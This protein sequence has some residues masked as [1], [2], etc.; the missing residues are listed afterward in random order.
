MKWI[1]EWKEIIYSNKK[2]NL[3]GHGVHSYCYHDLNKVNRIILGHKME[4]DLLW[5]GFLKAK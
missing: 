4:G 5:F 2:F 3:G 1:N